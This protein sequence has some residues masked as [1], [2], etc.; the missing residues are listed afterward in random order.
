MATESQKKNIAMLARRYSDAFDK[1]PCLNALRAAW[2]NLETVLEAAKNHG[3]EEIAMAV[4]TDG[5]ISSH[6]GRNTIVKTLKNPIEFYQSCEKLVNENKE[7][8]K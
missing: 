3:C 8:L 4:I 5:V 1:A 6:E 7:Y 2:V